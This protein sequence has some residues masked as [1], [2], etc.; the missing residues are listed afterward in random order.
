MINGHFRWYPQQMLKLK[1]QLR[2][3]KEK[4]N[5][6]HNEKYKYEAVQKK[7]FFLIRTLLVYH[8]KREEHGFSFSYFG[9]N[10]YA[11]GSRRTV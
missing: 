5:H 3:N 11:A 7:K 4:V 8:Y 9:E 10:Y 6:L 1:R 2:S